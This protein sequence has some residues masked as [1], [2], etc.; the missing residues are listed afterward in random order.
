M[1][2]ALLILILALTAASCSGAEV[3]ISQ[4][5]ELPAPSTEE[6]RLLLESS[7]EPIV[8]N[9]WASWCVPCRSEAPL[10]DKAAAA[11]PTVRFIGLNVRDDQT[12]ARQFVAE[13]FPEAEIEHLFDTGGDIPIELGGS[14]GPADVLLRTRRRT[15]HPSYRGDR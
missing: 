6:V 3:D 1:R 10:F 9:V 13:F 8:L 12:G 15:G 7:K 5:P 2:R 11:A 4:I 14:R